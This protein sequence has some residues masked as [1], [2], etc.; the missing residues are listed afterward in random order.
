M[1]LHIS[2]DHMCPN[3]GTY[4]I[5]F[6]QDIDCP[7]CNLM[8]EE[9]FDFISEAAK[10]AYYNLMN[11]GRYQPASWYTGSYADHILRLLFIVLENYRSNEINLPF[12]EFAKEFVYK[13]INWEDETFYREYFFKIACRVYSYIEDKK[14]ELSNDISSNDKGS[15]ERYVSKRWW[16]FWK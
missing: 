15:T 16:Q 13:K 4:Y 5:P 1:T 14:D 8:E 10:S 2:Y 7:K 6:D 9:I 3:C 11:E 12:N